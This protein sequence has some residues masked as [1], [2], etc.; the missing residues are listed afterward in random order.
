MRVSWAGGRGSP[1]FTLLGCLFAPVFAGEDEIAVGYSAGNPFLLP[2][3]T[4]GCCGR[5]APSAQRASPRPWAPLR[6]PFVQSEPQSPGPECLPRAGGWMKTPLVPLS[7]MSPLWPLP[8]EM[9]HVFGSTPGPGKQIAIWAAAAGGKRK[10]F[11]GDS[12]SFG[13]TF[14]LMF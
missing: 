10:R 6:S 7:T 4:A 14:R 3:L 2:S 1:P 8:R 13:C 12:A 9:T 5:A 11:M